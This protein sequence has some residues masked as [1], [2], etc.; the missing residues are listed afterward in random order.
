M[1]INQGV[2]LGAA[3]FKSILGDIDIAGDVGIGGNGGTLCNKLAGG[4]GQGCN[5]ISRFSGVVEQAHSSSVKAHI[6]SRE[7]F[8]FMVFSFF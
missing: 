8:D 4:R 2:E 3:D 5:F 1:P 6:T 7:A